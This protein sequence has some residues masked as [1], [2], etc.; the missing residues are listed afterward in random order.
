MAIWTGVR[1]NWQVV[2]LNC[3]AYICINFLTSRYIIAMK[4]NQSIRAAEL[5]YSVLCGRRRT[6]DWI[7]CLYSLFINGLV[8]IKPFS[9]WG[10]PKPRDPSHIY[11]IRSYI[12]KVLLYYCY[13]IISNPKS[14]NLHCMQWCNLIYS[15][16]V[17]LLHL[18]ILRRRN[19][20][21][22]DFD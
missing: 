1:D 4:D 12:L 14:C 5:D 2:I 3:S 18:Y 21:L 15:M 6:S 11:E 19:I 17:T 9:Y 16:V 22:V 10:E 8:L 13:F 20:R 7:W